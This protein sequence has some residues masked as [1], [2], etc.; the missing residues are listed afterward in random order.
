[1]RSKEVEEAIE[2]GKDYIEFMTTAGENAEWTEKVLNYIE[3]LE[4]T[5]RIL[6]NENAKKNETINN[7][8]CENYDMK[9]QL[10]FFIP[11]RRVRRVYKQL[12]KILVQDGMI[13]DLEDGD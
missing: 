11:R 12:G 4:K 10:Q 3:E 13:D 9:E 8:K 7:L 1:M 5:N 2:E 6:L